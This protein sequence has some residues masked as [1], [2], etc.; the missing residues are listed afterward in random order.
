[1]QRIIQNGQNGFSISAQLTKTKYNF[2]CIFG[3]LMGWD[4]GILATV[5]SSSYPAFFSGFSVGLS[6]FAT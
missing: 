4:G 2:Y 3:A 5:E 1:M 6:H